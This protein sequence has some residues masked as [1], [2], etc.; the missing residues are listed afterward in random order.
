MSDKLFEILNKSTNKTKQRQR[1]SSQ[2]SESSEE[3]YQSC[4]SSPAGSR[5][6]SPDVT[7]YVKLSEEISSL[8]GFTS[9]VTK[10]GTV[11]REIYGFPTKL[12]TPNE[13]ENCVRNFVE[14]LYNFKGEKK[15]DQVDKL[16]AKIAPNFECKKFHLPENSQAKCLVQNIQ[17]LPSDTFKKPDSVLASSTPGPRVSKVENIFTPHTT[18][19]SLKI[20][21]HLL[22]SDDDCRYIRSISLVGL[23]SEYSVKKFRS[24]LMGNNGVGWVQAEKVSFK[25]WF[26]KELNEKKNHKNGQPARKEIVIGKI[27]EQNIPTAV[28]HWA[29]VVTSQGQYQD[30]QSM[31]HCP[32][33]LHDCVVLVVGND[34]G[35]GYCREGIR[36][37]NRKTG[38]SG[39]KVFVTTL[40]E[41]TDKSLSLFQKQYLFSSLT[42]L[43]NLTS[44]RM[45]GKER[46]LIK[47]S[48]MDY[49]A[50]AE[51]FGTQVFVVTL[52]SLAELA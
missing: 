22:L 50:A 44:I 33:I 4:K 46:K 9:V 47:L 38:N 1:T 6:S 7:N 52:L 5:D 25:K 27:P 43:R 14:K 36:F 8:G 45:G 20:I 10:S 13:R 16:L 42:G 23:A 3:N 18:C 49:E 19:D 40:M 41:G 35:Q 37:C 21:N 2:S 12:L 51:D 32:P 26:R 48:C 31:E 28:Q 34:S 39:S 30:M 24:E 15:S 11:K 29:D 17:N